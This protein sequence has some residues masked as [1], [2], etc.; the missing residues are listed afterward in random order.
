MPY[1]PH[2]PAHAEPSAAA[3]HVHCPACGRLVAGAV[4]HAIGLELW[5]VTCPRCESTA[6]GRLS[7][8]YVLPFG[9]YSGRTVSSLRTAAGRDYLDYLLQTLAPGPAGAPVPAQGL[10]LAILWHLGW[11][12]PERAYVTAGPDLHR[13]RQEL[14]QFQ[15]QQ[16]Q[17]PNASHPTAAE[18]VR[19]EARAQR[20]ASWLRQ[21]GAEQERKRAGQP[22]KPQH[23]HEYRRPTEPLPPVSP[24]VLEPRPEWAAVLGVP[25][26]ATAKLIRRAYRRLSK[27]HHPDVGGSS[28]GMQKINQARDEAEAWLRTA[29]G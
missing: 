3:Y 25:W 16:A 23:F 19:A 2:V 20:H 9:P 7:P 29:P 11:L 12:S 22:K 14:H 4:A 24:A 8:E 28:T 18:K 5:A 26:P 1:P 13:M 17:L 27:R 21:F 6:P 15:R 10:R